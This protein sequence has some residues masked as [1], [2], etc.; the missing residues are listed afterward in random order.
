MSHNLFGERFVSFKR[1]AWHGLGHV[2]QS[3]MGAQDSFSL[4]GGYDITLEPMQLVS[5]EA[6]P[7]RAIMRE[8]VPDDPQRRFF[9][10]AG[11]EYHLISPLE[12]CTLWDDQV[13]QPLETI[14]ALH[15]GEDLFLSCRL[16]DFDVRG[17]QIENYM[18]LVSPYKS[19]VAIT[20]HI[21]PIRV[22]CQN[23]LTAGTKAATE[24]WKIRHDAGA[25]KSLSQW[26]ES[27]T[28]I[29]ARKAEALRQAFLM[30][31]GRSLK[32]VE[33][34]QVLEAAYPAAPRPSEYA[35]I[36]TR[37]KQNARAEVY[38][39]KMEER[40]SAALELFEGKMTG[41]SSIC[42]GTPWGIYN[43]VVEL[44]DCR[45]GRS[46]GS[47]AYDAVFGERAL[48]KARTYTACAEL[49]QN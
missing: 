12:V 23:T 9:G 49:C 38:D 27:V 21:T 33:V 39:R 36:V 14:G 13:K 41:Y 8:P 16:P 46:E 19:G 24:S 31:T 29:S 11:P 5:G 18:L 40:K 44:E 10:V 32:A 20:L 6:V 35:P 42:R 7:A 2:L 28:T 37:E 4:M 43:A 34:A 25:H 22:V 17:E 3:P 45:R 47:R 15:R 30:F 26:L 1:P 48:I